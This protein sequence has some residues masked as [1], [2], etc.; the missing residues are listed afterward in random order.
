VDLVVEITLLQ[1]RGSKLCL[2]I[3]STL[4]VQSHPS[5]GMLIAS[6][7]HTELARQLAALQAAV[8]STAQSVVGC[9]PT[10]AL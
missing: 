9:P 2:T 3:V 6:I 10:K 8:P 1:T 4:M 5:K 7:C